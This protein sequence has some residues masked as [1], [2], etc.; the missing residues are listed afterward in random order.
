MGHR[1]HTLCVFANVDTKSWEKKKIIQFL[2]TPKSYQKNAI[3]VRKDTIPSLAAE[4]K[5]CKENLYKRHKQQN[6]CSFLQERGEKA[7]TSILP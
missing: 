2:S 4:K 3:H 7:A 6:S 1:E 5:N